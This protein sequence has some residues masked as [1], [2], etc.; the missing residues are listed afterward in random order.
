MTPRRGPLSTL[1]W[2]GSTVVPLAFLGV[3]FAWPLF[4]VLQRS[5]AETNGADNPLDLL[6]RG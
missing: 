1:A 3:L 2:L 5:F 6:G 4:E